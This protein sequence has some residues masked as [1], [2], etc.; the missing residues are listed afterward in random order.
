MFSS[1]KMSC[2]C[3]FHC[4]IIHYKLFYKMTGIMQ[5]ILPPFI[6]PKYLVT[7]LNSVILSLEIAQ[8]IYLLLKGHVHL[9]KVWQMTE[10]Y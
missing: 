7:F 10:N 3:A 1:E 6:N 2:P 8:Y 5:C 9:E 4:M